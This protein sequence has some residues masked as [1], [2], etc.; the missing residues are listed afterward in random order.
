MPNLSSQ[1]QNLLTDLQFVPNKKERGEEGF[2]GIVF[3]GEY[4]TTFKNLDD[5]KSLEKIKPDAVY[6]FDKQPMILFFDYSQKELSAERETE[7]HKQAYNYDKPVIFILKNNEVHIFNAFSYH[8]ENGLSSIDQNDKMQFSFWKLQ[9][10]NT[11]EWFDKE[12]TKKQ[13]KDGRVHRELLNNIKVLREILD[14]EE[15][16]ILILRLIFIRYLIDRRVKVAGY[17]ESEGEKSAKDREAFHAIT[18]QKEKLNQLFD[19]LKGHFNGNLFEKTI[20]YQQNTLNIISEIFSGT[21]TKGSVQGLLD[22][23]IFDFGIIPIET[24]SGIYESI[25]APK[26]KEKDSAVY[27]PLFLANYVL[28]KA[29]GERNTPFKILDPACGSGIF[30]VQAFRRMVNFEKTKGKVLNQDDLN[31]LMTDCIFGIDRNPVA[32]RITIFSLY[33]AI[34]D[35]K[36]P[37][38]LEDKSTLPNLLGTNLFKADF[39]ENLDEEGKNFLAILQ[40]KELD[41]IIG[42]PPWGSK[43]EK[44]HNEYIESIT[45]E[46]R[47]ADKQIAQ[48]FSIRVR[49]FFATNHTTQIA[50][51]LT[52]KAF[53]NTNALADPLPENSQTREFKE[54]FFSRFLVKELLDLSAARKII[55]EATQK[56]NKDTEKRPSAPCL[57]VFYQND[58]R[59]NIENNI[60]NHFSVKPNLFTKQFKKLVIDE[61]KR[62]KQSFFVEYPFML[63]L[64]LY[65]SVLDFQLLKEIFE[66][67]NLTSVETFL[68]EQNI[69]VGAGFIEAEKNCN[70]DASKLYS[71]HVVKPQEIKEN[72]FWLDETFYDDEHLFSKLYSENGIPIS[73]I[74]DLGRFQAYEKSHLLVKRSID[75][76]AKV[77]F[78]DFICAFPNTIYGFQSSNTNYLKLLGGIFSSKLFAYLNFYLGSQWGIERDEIYLADYRENKIPKNIDNQTLQ[79]FVQ[80]FDRLKEAK[81]PQFE[82]L[83][84]K[85][86]SVSELAEVL[87][88]YALEINLDLFREKKQPYQKPDQAYLKRYAQVFWDHFSKI[89]D[90]EGEYFQIEIFVFDYFVAMKF[91]IVAEKPSETD[92]II[93]SKKIEENKIR[94]FFIELASNISIAEIAEDIF[95]QRNLKGFETD[96]FYIIK[97]NQRKSWHRAKAHED[98]AEFI[99]ALLFTE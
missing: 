62:V 71:Y 11:W 57:I 21:Y 67:E 2:V 29:L 31:K 16:D 50:F 88:D 75:K 48:S 83:V 12:F 28:D 37:K 45:D 4:D 43:N 70:A 95:I 7:I 99:D 98:L 14:H 47:I 20:D 30:L 68:T 3:R 63:K 51:I 65:G 19:H 60:V 44:A 87:I 49:D 69:F 94:D 10:G 32:L 86:Y 66:N 24:I 96:F 52:S 59:E 34:F 54:Y 56:S 90:T 41:F 46:V 58:T 9:S 22:F 26:D 97:P 89:Y 39:F 91:N 23:D 42:N 38:E 17:W 93:F 15:K 1:L 18:S 64:A 61:Q 5:Q 81:N 77:A 33:I 82:P 84:R 35:F 73:K 53:Y 8:K 79:L 25:I 74:K 55:F 40:E 78:A 6:H 76:V 27:T 85:L 36:T 13:K 72:S 80:E 92:Q